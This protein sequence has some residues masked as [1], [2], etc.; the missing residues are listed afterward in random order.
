MSLSTWLC[1]CALLCDAL[2]LAPEI[3]K[4][5][6]LRLLRRLLAER[7]MYSLRVVSFSFTRE[8]Y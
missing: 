8:P 2:S 1:T 7:K 6:G 3:N 5:D 4:P